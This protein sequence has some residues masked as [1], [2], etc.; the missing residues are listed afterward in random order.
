MRLNG[1]AIAEALY[2]KAL[3]RLLREYNL[4]ETPATPEA[5]VEV[6]L[7]NLDQPAI[8]D[9]G[10][11]Q[12]TN[13]DVY[14]AAVRSLGSGMR[15]WTKFIAN[16]NTLMAALG[17]PGAYDPE[18]AASKDPAD[19]IRFVP[20][21]NQGS[22][23]QAIIDW[24]NLLTQEPSYNSR[25]LELHDQVRALGS[26]EL[27]DFTPSEAMIVITCL[28][29]AGPPQAWK[30]TRL[31]KWPGMGY[32]LGSEFLRNLGWNG[33]KPDVHIMRLLGAWA[34]DVV[35]TQGQRARRLVKLAGRSDQELIKVAKYALA[36]IAITPT[37][38]TYSEADNLL[39]LLGSQVVKNKKN[40]MAQYTASD[41][42]TE[43]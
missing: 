20:G 14:R 29:A 13:S 41:F 38:M 4:Q 1:T 35:E 40:V 42:F 26:E 24:A 12:V 10:A 3:P 17:N 9:L 27:E 21:I 11:S 33:F 37:G 6:L 25:I 43:S 18:A 32:A 15:S 23:A 8:E 5:L 16:E 2:D 19:L 36:G 39:W 28:Q 22:T 34:E 30:G 31:A 7:Q